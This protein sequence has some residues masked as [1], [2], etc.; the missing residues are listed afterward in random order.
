MT[1]IVLDMDRGKAKYRSVY[2]MGENNYKVK[3]GDCMHC[4]LAFN[5]RLCLES[6]DCGFLYSYE[7][8]NELETTQ[9]P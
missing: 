6:P 4:D 7:V 1:E 8:T 9:L 2:E 3:L 5:D